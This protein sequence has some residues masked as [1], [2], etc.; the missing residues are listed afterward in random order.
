MW[1]GSANSAARRSSASRRK[2]CEVVFVGLD[3]PPED[4]ESVETGCVGAADGRR[5]CEASLGDFARAAC[6][7]VPFD[8]LHA[9]EGFQEIAALH[10]GDRVR[11]DFG[12]VVGRLPGEGRQDVRDAEFLFADDP[13][14]AL[15]QE[16][17]VGQQAAGDGVFD[18]RDA[19]QRRIGGHPGEQLVETQ[20]GQHLYFPVCEIA[21]RRRFVIASCDALYCDLFHNGLKKKIPLNRAGFFRVILIYTICIQLIACDPAFSLAIKE[22]VI[23]I[24]CKTVCSHHSMAFIV[25]KC[26]EIIRKTKRP[27]YFFLR[28]N[29]PL[30]CRNRL[31]NCLRRPN[32]S[33]KKVPRSSVSS[34]SHPRVSA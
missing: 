25:G 4:F 19:Q 27:P 21:A 1:A 11:A 7:V 34:T 17:V 31:R 16:L 22:K 20:A 3:A 13:G 8:D 15:L 6:G 5:A 24:V 10:Q 30:R 26:S 14:A 18:G 9:G 12:D 28:K 23:K 2:A 29:Q 32:A 33:R